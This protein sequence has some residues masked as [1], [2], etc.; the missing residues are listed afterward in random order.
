LK[1][2]ITY[3]KARWIYPV[4]SPP[5]ENGLVG[6]SAGK[7]V[8]VGR[9]TATQVGQQVDLGDGVILPA[10]INAHTHLELS[11][12][13]GRIERGLGFLPWVQQVL[14]LRGSIKGL[15]SPDAVG[16]SIEKLYQR[17]N[18]AVGDWTTG[19]DG[20]PVGHTAPLIRCRFYEI[21]GFSGQTL[22]LP[23]DLASH[24]SEGSAGDT[25]DFISLGAHAPHTTSA[26]L[27]QAAKKWTRDHRLTLSIH[28][29]ESREEAEFLL[30]GGGPW[31]AL[32]K[33]RNR[34][35]EGWSAP[36]LS[37]VA[38]L[39]RLG[40]LDS[41][42]Q[43]I[44]LTL[45]GTEDLKLIKKRQA[46]IVVCPRSNRFI[47]GTLPPLPEMLRLGIRPGLGTDSL[48]SNQ[49]LDLWEEMAFVQRSF[50]ALSPE[51]VLEMATR[52]GA[53]SLGLGAA[54]GSITSGK[55]AGLL[56]LPLGGVSLRDLP[57]AIIESRG[58][59]V[60]WIG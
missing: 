5:I 41:R 47:T 30:H 3:Y 52:N 20:T 59:N 60:Q 38:Y 4:D 43:C 7:I 57:A 12:L 26:S 11:A 33:E 19:F 27:L 37:P 1:T 34:W 54:L 21:I 6:V 10:L 13:H 42:T 48:A 29:A 51:T 2:E 17:G 25:S 49:D 56:F 58:K 16:A 22:V 9:R 44:H 23:E 18:I 28:L 35:P 36:G 40:L 32:L 31:Q 55:K 39:D 8:Q 50:S 46:R 14:T 15:E 53:E 24:G 45:A